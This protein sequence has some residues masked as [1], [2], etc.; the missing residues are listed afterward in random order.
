M[1]RTYKTALTLT[2]IL[3]LA[4]GI[5]TKAEAKLK[6][7]DAF[8]LVS[9]PSLAGSGSIDLS[10]YKGKVVIVDFWASWC[11]PCKV[12]L[13]YLDKLALKNK[14]KDLVVI[15]V[16]LDEKK[17]EAVAFLKSHPVQLP[18]AYDGE[19][20]TLVEKAE[21][22]VMPTSF[23]IDKK[24]VIA[25]RHE[26]FRSGDEAKIEKLISELMKK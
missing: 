3:S 14:G 6:K 4:L 10:K 19:K 9:L 24:G 26:A 12:E 7:G 22:E 18:I 25:D 21:I 15:G 1:K 17:A 13:P 8:P 23:I 20:K 16:N 5:V 11:E 2:F